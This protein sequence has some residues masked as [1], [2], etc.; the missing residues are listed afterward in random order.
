MHRSKTP[1]DERLVDFRLAKQLD[2]SS[3]YHT[4]TMLRR[5]LAML[6]AAIVLALVVSSAVA[7][8]RCRTQA[9]QRAF[10][11]GLEFQWACLFPAAEEDDEGTSVQVLTDQ[12]F[13]HLTQASTGATTG[14][15]FIKLYELVQ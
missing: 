5:S 6:F 3:Q 8:G 9:R 15:W 2:I 1:T 14:D 11:S 7:N 12:N 4:A 10:M 13:E